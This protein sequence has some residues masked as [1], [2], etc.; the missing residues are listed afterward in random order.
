MWAA[1]GQS[2]TAGILFTVELAQR[3]KSRNIQSFAVHPGVIFGT[4]LGTHLDG[5]DFNKI[6]AV[7]LKHT[8][9]PFEVGNIKTSQQGV[10]TTLVATLDPS[11]AEQTGSY[12]SDCKVEQ[13]RQYA[14]STESA[15]RLW[16]ISEDLVG[17]KFDF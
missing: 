13:T 17:E 7:A 16:K 1:Y 4:G 5:D 12:M 14:S 6:S 8:G 3:L 15:Q 10:S 11:I 2:K 9:R